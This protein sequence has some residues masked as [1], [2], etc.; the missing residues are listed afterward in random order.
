MRLEHVLLWRTTGLVVVAGLGVLVAAAGV[1]LTDLTARERRAIEADLRVVGRLLEHRKAALGAEA[2]LLADEPRLRALAATADVDVVTVEDVL[3]DVL[4]STTLE[5][6]TL[7]DADGRR[8]SGAQLT[9]PP[10][11]LARAL[12]G[13]VEVITLGD[14]LL[15]ASPMTYGSEVMGVVVA[16]RTYVD[17]WLADANA[18][19]GA[20]FIALG[21][22]NEPIGWAPRDGVEAAEARARA[23]DVVGSEW[24]WFGSRG[25][26]RGGGPEVVAARRWDDVRRPLVRLVAL[27]ALASAGIAVALGLATRAVAGRIARPIAELVEMAG[28]VARGEAAVT[29]PDSPVDEVA[30]LSSA[31]VKMADDLA[32]GREVLR[33]TERLERE[34]SIAVEIQRSILPPVVALPG[35]E[36]AAR[37]VPASEVGGDYFDVLRD[38][39]GGWVGIGD[40]TGHGLPAGLIM[41]MTQT[42]TAA[43]ARPERRDPREVVVALN[44]VLHDNI[45]HRMRRDDHVTF[46]LLRYDVD[47]VIRFAGAHEPIVLWRHAS[48]RCEIVETPGAWVGALPRLDDVTVATTLAL[49]PGDVLLLHTD[50]VTESMNGRRQR[51]GLERLVEVLEHHAPKGAEASCAAIFAAVEAWA[52]TQDDD[53]T[54]IVARY[55]GSA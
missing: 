20:S 10:D 43:L 55:V 46:S 26:M 3:T 49:A 30:A 34:M 41:L 17:E 5:G 16:Y 35:L 23:E 8:L 38:G 27:L 18:Q 25:A 22:G 32:A 1:V 54:V 37:M 13:E 44:R 36:L 40:V 19:T 7:F 45:R 47:G 48:G 33:R 28:A 39:E 24:R 11:V 15:A 29:A 42:A 52:P 9:A 14:R 51:F 6:V 53:R 50:G 31:M 12:A 2:R 4:R 21:E